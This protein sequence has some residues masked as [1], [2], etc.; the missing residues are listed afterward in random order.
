VAESRSPNSFERRNPLPPG[1]YWITI[2][3]ND[4]DAFNEWKD[5]TKRIRLEAT[6]AHFDDSPPFEFHV[7]R[8]VEPGDVVWPQQFG[9]PSVAKESVT[10][11]NEVVRAPEIDTPGVT[12]V[13]ENLITLGKFAA[14]GLGLYAVAKIFGGRR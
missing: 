5:S 8:I 3:P 4:T 6:E 9:F 13:L 10:S 11:F 2:G 7:F 1:R 12:D 14:V